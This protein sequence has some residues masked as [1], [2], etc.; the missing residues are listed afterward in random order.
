MNLIKY[1]YILFIIKICTGCDDNHNQTSNY[2]CEVYFTC[3]DNEYMIQTCKNNT[4]FFKNRCIT[5]EV[6]K[7]I[8]G[9]KCIKCPILIDSMVN[10][11]NIDCSRLSHGDCCYKQHTKLIY[12]KNN[13]WSSI[14]ASLTCEQLLS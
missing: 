13:V 1:L 10:G 9:F 5:Q 7:S 4:V 3:K 8:N 6:Y 14:E 2:Y 12:C 11:G